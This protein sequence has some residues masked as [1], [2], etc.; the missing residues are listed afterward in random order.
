M[1]YYTIPQMLLHRS[2]RVFSWL[3]LFFLI[4]PILI[5]IPLSFNADPFFTFTEGMLSLDPDAYSLRWYTEFI[6]SPNWQASIV[7]SLI[8]GVAAMIMAT[9]LGTIA[10]VG[11]TSQHMPAKGLITAILIS[12]MIVPLIITAAGMFFFYAKI[13][14]VN[15]LVGLSLAHTVLGIPFVIIT[16]SA[17]L[18]GFDQSLFNAA[19][20]LGASSLRAFLDITFPIIRPGIISGALFALV[21]SFDEVILVLFLAGP[22]QVTIPRQ[23]FSGLREQINPTILAVASVLVAMSA[24]LLLVLELMRRKAAKLQVNMLNTKT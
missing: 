7:N 24:L 20:S 9:I 4:S 18:A 16:V 21:T 3:I 14:L 2:T 15:S 13:N 17:T 8:V 22:E 12:P 23:M 6:T 1:R 5:I 11:L 19:K 10:S